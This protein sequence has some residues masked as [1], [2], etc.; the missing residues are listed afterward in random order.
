MTSS[1][2]IEFFSVG[3]MVLST[4]GNHNIKGSC[5]LKGKDS[6]MDATIHLEVIYN[7]QLDASVE[8]VGEFTYDNL[9]TKFKDLKEQFEKELLIN[10]KEIN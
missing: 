2:Y 10:N 7:N 9:L 6:N 5:V 8:D 1:E 3:M 4:N